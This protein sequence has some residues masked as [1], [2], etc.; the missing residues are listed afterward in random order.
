MAKKKLSIN[1]Q[2]VGDVNMSFEIPYIEESEYRRDG[3]ETIKFIQRL[4]N[5]RAY[6]CPYCYKRIEAG[7]TC[8]CLE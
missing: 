5:S 6:I 4:E 7:Q 2:L 3:M 1:I 8:K